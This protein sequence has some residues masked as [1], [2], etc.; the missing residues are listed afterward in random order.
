MRKEEKVR[1]ER[2]SGTLAVVAILAIFIL[3]FWIT[4]YLIF[5]SRG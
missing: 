2:P 5:L 4:V 1:G 3:V